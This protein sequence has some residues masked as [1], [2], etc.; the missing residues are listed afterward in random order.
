LGDG[1]GAYTVLR[2]DVFPRQAFLRH[3]GWS[4]FLRTDHWTRNNTLRTEGISSMQGEA[5]GK[6][7]LFVSYARKDRGT[8]QPV[9]DGIERLNFSVWVDRRLEG[10]Q[11]WWEEIL[12]QIR[13]CDATLVPISSALLTSEACTS[14]RGYAAA[15]GKPFLPVL[16]SPVPTQM[17]PRDLA[18]LQIVDYTTPGVDATFELAGALA[19]LRPPSPLPDPL[20]EPPGIPKSYQ[21]D[22]ADKINASSLSLQDQLALVGQL[23]GFMTQ[24]D[25]RDWAVELL[26]GMQTRHDLY[27]AV[28]HQIQEALEQALERAQKEDAAP[29][30]PAGWYDDPSGRHQTRWFDR[31]WTS[32]VADGGVVVD[33]P[34]T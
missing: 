31:D 25:D 8:L 18:M 13:S 9:L 20:P 16:I 1:T 15:L 34:L 3:G 11:P 24:P 28:D 30:V 21:Y 22:L 4:G 29:F 14:E 32:W 26:K 6:R 12:E 19:G 27:T 10:G 2:I 23:R 33:D 5:R 17:I 7:K